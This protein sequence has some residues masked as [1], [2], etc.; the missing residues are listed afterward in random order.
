VVW[1]AGAGVIGFG[2]N[3]QPG[4][5]RNRG[6]SGPISGFGQQWRD[7]AQDLYFSPDPLQLFLFFV[8][9]FVSVAHDD[10]RPAGLGPTTILSKAA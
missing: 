6:G 1:L 7:C 4:S 8:K 9:Q 5:G 3:D 10:S 2:K